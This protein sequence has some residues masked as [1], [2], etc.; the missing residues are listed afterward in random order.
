MSKTKI[1]NIRGIRVLPYKI[2]RFNKGAF[3][4][5]E[6]ST[7]T[8]LNFAGFAA[9]GVA[10]YGAFDGKMKIAAI[11]AGA[12]LLCL[13]GSVQLLKE[14]LAEK[15]AEEERDQMWR[16]NENIHERINAVEQRINRRVDQS[17][18]DDTV[19]DIHSKIED[20]QR[21][22]GLDQD[23]VYRH[24]AEESRD[25]HSRID[26]VECGTACTSKRK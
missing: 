26:S 22:I 10:A 13:Y 25:I 15:K 17:T 21:D 7:D 6:I 3:I 8:V 12:G 24:I 2:N 16:E 14:K 9:A 5:R 20:I 23:A 4:M 19:R 11:A 1:Y 18:F